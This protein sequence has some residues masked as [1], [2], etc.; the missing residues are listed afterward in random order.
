MV[1]SSTLTLVLVIAHV[2]PGQGPVLPPVPVPPENPITE[3]KRIL[4]KILFWEEQLSTDNT[5]ACGTCHRPELGGVDP[6]TAFHPGPDGQ[7]GGAD[8]IAGSPGVARADANRDFVPDPVFGSGIQVTRRRAPDFT[9]AAYQPRI[10]WDGRAGPSFID[11]DTG[12]VA[13]ATGGALEAQAILPLIAADEMAHAGRTFAQATAKLQTA[14]PMKLA[15][16]LPPDVA[17]ALAGGPTYP[18]LFQAA[19]G[20]PEITAR[21]IAFALATYERTLVANQ[22]PLDVWNSGQP[23]PLTPDQNQGFIVFNTV[24]RCT[25]CHSGPTFSDGLFRNLGIRPVTEDPGRQAVTGL[26]SDRGKFKTSSLRNVALRGRFFHNGRTA[27]LVEA[28]DFYNGGGPFLDNR[29]LLL[30]G[31]SFTA[32]QRD[33]MVAFLHA[34]TDP[35]AATGAFPFDRP[36]LHIETAAPGSNLFGA[37]TAGPLGIVPSILGHVPAALGTELKIGLGKAAGG[38]QAWLGITTS[39][40]LPPILAGGVQLHVDPAALIFFVPY[41]LPGSGAGSGYA[42]WKFDLPDVGAL[43]GLAV[44]AQWLVFDPP[45]GGLSATPGAAWMLF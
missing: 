22:T 31:L 29:D 45:S 26:A 8:D 23:N 17:A 33:L 5:V 39:P 40:A 24:G 27:S 19:F 13:I 12:L 7:T 2:L 44:Y 14:K 36:T 21:R 28:V 18:D 25:I 6:R 38:A 11:P 32:A 10:L 1:R 15:T 30:N 37:P 20:T 3:G 4:G 9:A 16:N 35:R 42:T 43:A 41:G 34:L